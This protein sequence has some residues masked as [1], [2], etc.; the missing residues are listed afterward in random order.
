[1]VGCG[2]GGGGCGGKVRLGGDG[3]KLSF[4]GK[5]EMK[6]LMLAERLH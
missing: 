2:T 5:G 4:A 1:M 3:R 6:L